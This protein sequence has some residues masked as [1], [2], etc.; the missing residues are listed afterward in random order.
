VCQLVYWCSAIC[1]VSLSLKHGD[2]DQDG[3]LSLQ[4][5]VDNLAHHFSYDPVLAEVIS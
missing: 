3:Y 2:E 5:L 4:E 1:D